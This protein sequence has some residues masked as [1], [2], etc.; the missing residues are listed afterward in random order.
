MIDLRLIAIIILLSV[1]VISL[2]SL[3]IYLLN[4]DFVSSKIPKPPK[5]K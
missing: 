4:D 2:L 3:V 1:F 5:H